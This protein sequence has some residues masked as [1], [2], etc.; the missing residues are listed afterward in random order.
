VI[1]GV[2]AAML[3][4]AGGGVVAWRELPGWA[5]YGL[6]H[7]IRRTVSAGLSTAHQEIIFSG[8]DDGAGG[9]VS[10]KGWRLPAQGRRLG[11][12]VILH[13]VA[14]HRGSLVSAANR[15]SQQGFEV[16]TYD[17]RANG[18]SGGD[19]CTYGYY[20]KRDLQRVLDTVDG[21]PIIV[22]GHSLGGAVA[23]QAAAEDPRIDAVV[24]AESFSDLRTVAQERAWF[25]PSAIARRAFDVAEA[26]GRFE[27]DAVSPALA[28]A[29]ITVPVLL[30]HGAA[31]RAT[32]PAHSQRIFAA[33]AG[34]KRLLIVDGAGH[35][36]SL[37]SS[38]WQSIDR[39]LQDVLDGALAKS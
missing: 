30:V 11:T 32:L 34:P 28:A 25:L 8:A 23:L 38:T 18:D 3:A 29:R 33:L 12:I 27:V 14:D 1:L 36:Q 9:R 6:L 37:R 20:E 39:W 31:D 21:G 16:I 15:F 10:L 13:G 26:Q 4:A 19:A 7:P 17:S 5:A 22:I 35:N 2:A 24:A